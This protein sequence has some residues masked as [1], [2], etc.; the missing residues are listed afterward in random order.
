MYKREGTRSCQLND[1]DANAYVLLSIS[2]SVLRF[3]IDQLVV[4]HESHAL[5]VVQTCH[6]WCSAELNMENE[7]RG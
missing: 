1:E 7:T 2:G 4:S 6:M 5:C 3:V